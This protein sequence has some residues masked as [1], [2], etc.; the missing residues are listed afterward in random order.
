MVGKIV[1]NMPE[2]KYHGSPEISK[3]QLCDFYVSPLNYWALH[4][5]PNR[6]PRKV[7]THFDVGTAAHLLVLEGEKRFFEGVCVQPD[8]NRRTKAGREEYAEFLQINKGKPILTPEDIEMVR[9]M[10]D[11]VHKNKAS[12][13]ELDKM[14]K[15][16]VSVFYNLK[17]LDMRSR[18]DG[19]G[20]RVI[21]DLKTTDNPS[22]ANF[23][24]S[25]KKY[26][27]DW[28]ACL[29]SHAYNVAYGEFP[30]EFVFIVVGKMPPHSVGVYTLSTTTYQRAMNKIGPTIKSFLKCREEDQWPD[31]NNEQKIE[32]DV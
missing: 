9:R 29:Y 13:A 27:Y 30:D 10:S 12:R 4:R 11:A 22:V 28:Q 16:E 24:A 32:L 17:G 18:F 21:I 19:V 23:N 6:P 20:K 26:K 7:Y 14:L 15:V 25:I 31:I 1:D 5:N 3:S 8:I 2:D